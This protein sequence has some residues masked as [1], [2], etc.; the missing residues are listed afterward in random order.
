MD[1]VD[2]AR[3][4][5][6]RAG[7]E[8]E[9]MIG[10]AIPKPRIGVMLEVPSM[11]FMLPQLA[12][13]VDFISVGTNDLTQYILAVDRNNT[14]VASIYDSL[15]PAII[16]A[17]AMI[18]REAEQYGIDLRLCGEMAG[19]SM[20]VAILI[21]LGYRHLSMNGRSCGAREIPA[22]AYR[23]CRRRSAG[24]AGVEHSDDHRSAPSGG[25]VYGT[26]RYGRPDP[27]RPI[28]AVRCDFLQNFSRP[29]GPDRA[30]PML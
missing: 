29:A 9:E 5:I 18:A 7:R 22:A 3:R 28:A 1:E 20:C 27:R 8:V 10:Y 2:E 21:G 13:R 24:A 6:E 15:H 26:T 23:H 11:V 4:L 16:R 14:R 12:N 17:L 30:K 19:D 25:G